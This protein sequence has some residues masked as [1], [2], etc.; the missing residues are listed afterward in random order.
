MLTETDYPFLGGPRPGL[1]KDLRY[2]T[3]KPNKCAG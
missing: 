2:K 1:E 3:Y